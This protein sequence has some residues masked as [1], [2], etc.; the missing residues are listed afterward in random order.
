MICGVC[1][2]EISKDEV[3]VYVFGEPA[4]RQCDIEMEA[5]CN[6]ASCMYWRCAHGGLC[7]T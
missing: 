7:V 1:E 4:H 6:N 5:V 2:E 3:P